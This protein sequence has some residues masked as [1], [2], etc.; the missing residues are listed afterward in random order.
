MKTEMRVTPVDAYMGEVTRVIEKIET[1]KQAAE[2][3]FDV[4]PDSVLWGNVGN[5]HHVNKSLDEIIAFLGL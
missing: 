4:S 5:L 3:H 2:N 1:L